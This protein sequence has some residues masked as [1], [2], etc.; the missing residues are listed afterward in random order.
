MRKKGRDYRGVIHYFVPY[1]Y[2][3]QYA[4]CE[5]NTILKDYT[6]IIGKLFPVVKRLVNCTACL[7]VTD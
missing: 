2:H 1:P 4:I 3:D 7:G 5:F 6:N